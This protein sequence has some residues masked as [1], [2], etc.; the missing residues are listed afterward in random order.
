MEAR[1]QSAYT[2]WIHIYDILKKVEVWDR[3]QI[4]DCQGLEMRK[5]IDFKGYQRT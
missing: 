1:N 2:I 3:M 5:E 4:S